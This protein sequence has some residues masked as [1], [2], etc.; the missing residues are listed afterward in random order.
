MDEGPVGTSGGGNGS[1]GRGDRGGRRGSGGGQDLLDRQIGPSP[2]TDE[3]L[4]ELA[5]AADPTQPLDPGAVPL[6][7]YLALTPGLLP[8]WY[9]PA[10]TSRG[11]KA[12]KI[13]VVVVILAAFLLVDISGL[14]ST[15]G[16]IVPV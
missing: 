15:Y 8:Q 6:S 3:E 12:W 4:A 11:S 10:P 16:S 5:L 7:E 9:M 2:F 13:A 1:G 14:C